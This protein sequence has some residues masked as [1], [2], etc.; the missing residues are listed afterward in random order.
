MNATS[1][2]RILI[3]GAGAI[4][5]FYG[6]A[7]QAGGAEVSAVCRSDYDAVR[8]DG[9]IVESERLGERHFLPAQTLRAPG[10]YQGGPPDYLVLSVKV[11]EGVDRAALIRDA[12]GPQTAIVLIE[13]GVEIEEEIAQAFP[14][15]EL[16]SALAFVQ[17]SRVAP[18]RVRHFA[19]GELMFGNYPSGLSE[20]SRRFAALLEAGGIKARTSDAVVTARWQKCVW[21]AAFNPISVLGG[22]LDTGHILGAEGGTG[23]VR[24]VMEEI[25]AIAAAAG[26]P[27]QQGLIDQYL[28]NTAKAPPYKTSMALDFEHGRPMETEV[29]LGNAV[30]AGRR[31]G[32]HAPSLETMYALMKMVERKTGH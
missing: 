22:V 12:V 3:I 9:V 15:N 21:N 2:D 27:Q 23:F 8:R 26:H 13:N 29:I 6:A 1:K 4:G 10:D 18:G 28:E 16:I 32:V 30:R 5:S 7:L 11:I 19:F 14:D 20:R 17:V 25:C 24:K 31:E